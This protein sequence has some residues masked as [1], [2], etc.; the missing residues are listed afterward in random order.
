MN[1]RPAL[2][3]GTP[4]L[5]NDAGIVQPSIGRY[6]DDALMDRLRSI[7][8][9]NMVTNGPT[10]RELER[11]MASYL[12]VDDVAAVSSC[13]LGLTLAIQAAGLAGKKIILP[14][15]TIAAT[16]NAAYWNGC[17][18]VFVDVDLDTFNISTDHLAE[19]V[20]ED[21]GAIMPVHVFG[22]PCPIDEVQAIADRHGIPVV[23]DAAQGFGARYQG[24]RL[25]RF[26][27][28]EVF[29]GSPTKHF[30]SLEGGFVAS[31]D[32][33]LIRMVRLTRNYGVLPNYDCV[34]QGLNA[35][36][37]ETNAAVGLAIMPH[38]DEFIANRNGYAALYQRLLAEVPGLTFQQLTPDVESSYN[39]LGIMVEPAQFGITNRELAEALEA[40]RVHTK[41]YY[42]PA[43][44]QQ[45][46]Y[47]DMAGPALPNTEY[48]VERI[49]CLPLYNHMDES[50]IEAI[51]AAVRRIHEH[52][53]Q[54][55]ERMAGKAVPV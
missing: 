55:K 31:N 32:P 24:E 11:D 42:H 43:V 8:D 51:C 38:T 13:T 20:S 44:H 17:Q 50:L 18:P 47:R 28:W 39:Y 6:T 27:R 49:L 52:R 7:L 2:L 25:G 22:N 33:E 23:Y 16:A 15:F 46:A 37:P 48:L 14:S 45:T 26:G 41:V 1:D 3:G 9:S 10:V 19:L 29:S 5:E 4:K 36:M 35:R 34:L 30:T 54:V 12:E 53:G 21:I 40:E